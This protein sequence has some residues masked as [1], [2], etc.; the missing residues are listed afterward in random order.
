MYRSAGDVEGNELVLTAAA[1]DVDAVPIFVDERPRPARGGRLLRTCCRLRRRLLRPLS[2]KG[3]ELGISRRLGD[4]CCQLI[5]ISDLRATLLDQ[6]R[7]LRLRALGLAVAL[8][9]GLGVLVRGQIWIEWDRCAVD[10]QRGWRARSARDRRRSTRPRFSSCSASAARADSLASAA[11]RRSAF[12][13]AA[14]PSR[15]DAAAAG[16]AVR[17]WDERRRFPPVPVPPTCFAPS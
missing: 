2:G 11:N 15:V 12:C 16:R 8:E 9:V 13:R 1:A 14:P 10:V 17:D 6:A 5:E 3:L 7:Q 4:H